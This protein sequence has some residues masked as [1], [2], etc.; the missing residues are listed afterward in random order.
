MLKPLLVG[1][2]ALSYKTRGKLRSHCHGPK[3]LSFSSRKPKEV[4]QAELVL[5][6][7][8]L[9]KRSGA[10]AQQA[11]NTGPWGN[12]QGEAWQTGGLEA[13][14]EDSLGLH[15]IIHA[16]VFSL[17]GDNGIVDCLFFAAEPWRWRCFSAK[18]QKHIVSSWV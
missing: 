8:C 16:R 10:T 18:Q 11:K 9:A 4:P 5:V 1:P 17:P 12:R 15:V 3:S 13:A 6:L 7:P 2:L 14:A